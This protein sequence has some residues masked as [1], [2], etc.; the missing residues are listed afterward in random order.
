MRIVVNLPANSNLAF[1]SEALV[2]NTSDLKVPFLNW[3][4]NNSLLLYMNAFKND[5]SFYVKGKAEA[6]GR[7][8]PKVFM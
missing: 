8:I 7:K 5:Y 2:M 6:F 1:Y 4:L 3:N